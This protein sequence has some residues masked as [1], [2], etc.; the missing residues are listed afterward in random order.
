MKTTHLPKLLAVIATF[1]LLP[2][3]FLLAQ[4]PLT[5]PGTPAPTMKSLDQIEPRT[6]V[7]AAHTPGDGNNI[8]IITNSGSFYL[9]TNVTAS[10][11]KNGIRILADNVTIDLNGFGLDGAGVGNYGII[12]PLFLPHHRNITVR[13]GSVRNWL[14]QG[15]DLSFSQNIL[16]EKIHV[17]NNGGSGIATGENSVV[18]D[19]AA[20]TNATIA[21]AAAGIGVNAGSVVVNC[22]ADANGTGNTN[23][24][25]IAAGSSCTITH[26]SAFQNNA[27][28][29]GGIS[30]GFH[31]TVIDCTA[32]FN[33][34]NNGVGII[35]ATGGSV[36]HCTAS[37]N[38]G[39]GGAGIAA[40][41]RTRIENCTATDNGGDGIRASNECFIVSN[42]CGNNG[43]PGI[44][45]LGQR[46]RIDGNN[47]AF[48]PGGGIK[49]DSTGSFIVRNS[50]SGNSGNNY[51][52]AASNNDAQRLGGG[53]AFAST[54]PW[55][56]FSF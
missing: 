10:S 45:T 16:L 6:P 4:G 20:Y 41:Q 51:V 18:R 22:V 7:D 12:T 27:V 5:P 1:L 54:D 52:I 47:V 3:T 48:N 31:S 33:S 21:L 53:T 50:V 42:H 29:G 17:S 44:H 40:S 26:C 56:N 28:N 8:F 13:N 11:A 24:F 15:I 35:V 25:G 39:A 2:A 43:G 19:C 38:G 36:I 32:S 34:G 46:N 37:A 55:A 49:V 14:F 23:C 30:S 9:T